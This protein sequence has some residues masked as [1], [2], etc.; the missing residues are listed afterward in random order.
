MTPEELDKIYRAK[1]LAELASVKSP[2]TTDTCSREE[3]EWRVKEIAKCKR[4]ISYFAQNWFKIINLDKGLMT[5]NMYEKQKELLEFFTKEKRCMVLAA[6]QSGKCVYKDT[7][8]TL[9]NKHTG[10]IIVIDLEKFFNIIAEKK[11]II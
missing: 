8:I 2:G 4:S 3:F 9:R 11:K 10:E 6:R 7:E 1:Y 5:I